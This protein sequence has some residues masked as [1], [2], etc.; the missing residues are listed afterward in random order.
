MQC[1]NSS[2]FCTFHTYCHRPPLQAIGKDW[3]CP[4]CSGGSLSGNLNNDKKQIAKRIHKIM[5]RKRVRMND[6][7]N[8]FQDQFLLKWVSLSHCHDSRVCSFFP[9]GTLLFIHNF[10]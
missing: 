7:K 3:L 9:S 10:A 4:I 8:V 5:G 6:Q 2:C 1:R